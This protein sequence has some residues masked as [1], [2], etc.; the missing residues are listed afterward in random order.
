M[1]ECGL[2]VF[3]MEFAW[4]QILSFRAEGEGSSEWPGISRQLAIVIQEGKMVGI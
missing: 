2:L 1:E 3:V 4:V